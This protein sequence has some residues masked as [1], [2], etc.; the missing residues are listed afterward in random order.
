[1]AIMDGN[2]EGYRKNKENAA[3]VIRMCEENEW[4]RTSMSF[5]STV[6]SEFEQ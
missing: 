4:D 2:S 5:S 3:K 1:M 6:T